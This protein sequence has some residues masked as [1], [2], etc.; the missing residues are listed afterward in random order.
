V[1]GL[2]SNQVAD[3]R[4]IHGENTLTK[5]PRRG[6]LKSFLANFGDPMLRILLIALGIQVIFV[7]N[8]GH[9]IETFGIAIAIFVAVVVSTLSEYGSESAFKKLQEQASAITARAKRNGET[10]IIPVAD[11]VV[12]DIIML[13]TGDKVPADG[14]IVQGEL[15]VD[16][17]LLNGESKEARKV[18][19]RGDLR[20]P[21]T[22]TDYLNPNT[23]FSGT[24][25]TSGEAL[26]CVTSVGDKTEYGKIA[27]ELQEEMPTS[28]LKI[29]LQGLARVISIFGYIGAALVF[30]AYYINLGVR[31]EILGDFAHMFEHFLRAA[32]L[33][34]AVVV[35]SVPEGLPMMI[36]VVLSSNMKHMLRDNVLVRKLNGIET[37][38]SMNILFTD[39]TGTLTHGKLEVVGIVTGDAKFTDVGKFNTG[40]ALAQM[41]GTSLALNTQAELTRDGHA[42]G[43]NS[44]DRILLKFA[45]SLKPLTLIKSSQT[46]FNSRDKFMSTT[47]TDGRVLLKGAYEVLAP[48]IKKYLN[49][50]GAPKSI[51]CKRALEQQIR[52]LSNKAYRILAVMIDDTL[53]AL[54]AIRDQVRPE[55]ITAVNRLATAGIQTVMITGDAPETAVAVAREVGILDDAQTNRRGDLWSPVLTSD[56]LA[57]LSDDDLRKILPTLR[58]VARALPS[59]KSRLVRIAQSLNLVAGMTGDGVND[60]PALKIADIGFAMGSGTEVAKEAGDIVILDD[61]IDSISK[62]VSYGRTI[63]KSIRKFLIFKLTINLCAVAVSIIAPLLNVDTP[64]TVIQMLWINFVMD[65]L[66]GLAFGGERPRSEYMREAPKCRTEGIIN[67]YMWWQI[68]LTGTFTAV[69]SLWFITS[70]F[71][72]NLRA[73]RGPAYALT[74]FFAFFMLINIINSFNART[75][76]LNPF[77]KIGLNRPFIFIMGAVTIIQITLIYIGGSIFR[78]TP[79]DFTHLILVAL[80]AL[81]V[82]PFDALRKLAWRKTDVTT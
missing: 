12:G 46:P 13:G 57:K 9:W 65:T 6:L 11:I 3:S 25:V 42:V 15:E 24:V 79:L 7:F 70:P 16:Q 71:M 38:G 49:N 8:T 73:D 37:A 18:A 17:S 45:K 43:G 62:G 2:T 36:T 75:H 82:V 55:A 68:I 77:N 60:A 52:D 34:V 74:T 32:T 76:S 4:K 21:A 58:V 80:L 39:K 51:T 69:V 63:F 66:A 20:S 35:M 41:L 26:M 40:S 10:Q 56:Q 31:G 53:V 29:K 1:T 28:P 81:S 78:T 59:D 72:Q 67:R 44:T 48:R 14:T 5:R 23:L 30:L 33:V 50:T 27:G 19:C 47:L 61:N 22:Q 64:I 54:V